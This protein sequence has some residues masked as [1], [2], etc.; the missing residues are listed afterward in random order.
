MRLTQLCSFLKDY[1]NNEEADTEAQQI[2]EYVD[3][4][5]VL[6]ETTMFKIDPMIN[7]GQISPYDFIED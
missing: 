6:T 2:N 1:F 5:T 7:M 3:A 4:D